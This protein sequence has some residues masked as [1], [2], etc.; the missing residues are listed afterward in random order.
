MN[1]LTSRTIHLMKTQVYIRNRKELH[2]NSSV[3]IG[4]LT[5]QS[6]SIGMHDKSP[7]TIRSFTGLSEPIGDKTRIPKVDHEKGC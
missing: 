2:D 6:E 4:L 3:P 1:Q 5:E 7:V